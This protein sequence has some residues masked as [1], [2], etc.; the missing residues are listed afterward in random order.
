MPASKPLLTLRTSKRPSRCKHVDD[1]FDQ[2]FVVVDDQ[3][4]PLA[5]FQGVGRNA[6]VA[7]EQ[8]KLIARNAAESASRHAKTLE[9]AGVEAANNRLLA[10]LANLGGFTG[11][12][13]CLH[14]RTTPLPSRWCS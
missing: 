2:F 8:K 3:D 10:D 12:K 13:Y 11:R 6:V 1:Q 14:L 7:H 4:L 5:A 9:L